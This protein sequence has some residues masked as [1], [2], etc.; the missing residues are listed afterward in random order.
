MFVLGG[1]VRGGKVYGKWPGLHA[2]QLFED[3][4]LARTTNFRTVLAE[5]VSRHLGIREP[6]AVFPGF[7]PSPSEFRGFLS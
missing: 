5:I 6:A 3:R 1:D 2:E 7:R 4:D